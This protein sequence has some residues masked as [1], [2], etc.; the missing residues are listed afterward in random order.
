MAGAQVLCGRPW[1]PLLRLRHHCRTCGSLVCSR[2][3]SCSQGRHSRKCLRCQ[4]GARSFLVESFAPG[5]VGGSA[6]QAEPLP[7]L[8]LGTETEGLLQAQIQA[9][10]APKIKK[11]IEASPPSERERRLWD[12]VVAA[13][14]RSLE[15]ESQ[16]GWRLSP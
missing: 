3:S 2:C 8:P 12:R 1:N 15:A 10:L 5:P 4:A 9:A 11:K 14:K 16:A 7:E 6:P 13:E